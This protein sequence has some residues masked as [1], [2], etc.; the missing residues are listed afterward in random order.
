MKNILT[1]ILA[2]SI[3]VSVSF[4]AGDTPM[5][6]QS[7]RA[8]AMGNAFLAFCD[9]PVTLIYNPAGLS[10]VSHFRLSTKPLAIDMAQFNGISD[11]VTS[12]SASMSGTSWDSMTPDEQADLIDEVLGF[13][14]L[15]FHFSFLNMALIIPTDSFLGSFGTGLYATSNFDTTIDRGLFIPTF[16]FRGNIDMLLP[17]A[18]SQKINNFYQDFPGTLSVG[19]S[20]NIL[21]MRMQLGGF[22]GLSTLMSGDNS[23]FEDILKSGTASGLNL[24]FIYQF[25]EKENLNFGLVLQDIGGTTLNWK[26]VSAT[27]TDL[28]PTKINSRMNV[29]VA[30]KPIR[31]YYFPGKYIRPNNRLS[32]TCDINNFASGED[33]LKNSHIGAEWDPPVFFLPLLRFGFNSGWFTWGFKMGPLEY[34]YYQEE[35]G[36]FAGAQAVQRSY[37]SLSVGF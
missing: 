15:S 1:A 22:I 24:G 36:S 3:M 18:F 10:F 32:L 33:M 37:L 29:G 25:P 9:D 16:D 30:W 13:A 31:L 4:A 27:P 6:V 12:I 23:V 34:A 35:I 7:L 5:T 17:I 8:Y 28:A 21:L 26:T 2:V 19:I 20:M 11:L 14:N